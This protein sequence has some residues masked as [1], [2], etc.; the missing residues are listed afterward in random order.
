MSE[1]RKTENL[2]SPILDSGENQKATKKLKTII[3][4]SAVLVLILLVVL[5]ILVFVVFGTTDSGDDSD[6]GSIIIYPNDTYTHCIIWLHGLG[7][8]PNKFVDLFTKNITFAK[9]NN[10]KIILMHAPN[11]SVSYDKSITT[12]W[13]DIYRFPI[14]ASDTYNFDDAK[15]SSQ[16]VQKI[17]ER[18][19]KELGGKYE[20]IF[21]GGHS[22]GA[23]VTL[24]TGYTVKYLLGGVL[25][26][27]GILFPQAEIV[28]NKTTL[29]VMLGHGYNDEAIP[30][31][32]HN[33]TVEIISNY[34]GVRRCYYPY[35]G[36]EIGINETIDMGIFLN[37]TM[38]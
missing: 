24:L 4:L 23:C 26:C 30:L 7:S 15:I 17:I 27:S 35:Q 18:E 28:G 8:L 3:I 32:Y 34:S 9:R 37:E 2:D 1:E 19:A 29:N 6:D 14:N 36:H 11:T 22:Q 21:I 5:F 16:K 13:F 33:E 20:N 38:K 12:S 25:V 31:S 10:T